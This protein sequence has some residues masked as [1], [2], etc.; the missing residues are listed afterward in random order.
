MRAL[1]E[2]VEEFTGINLTVPHFDQRC[3]YLRGPRAYR[4]IVFPSFQTRARHEYC[5]L[6]RNHL[7]AM[8]RR[9]LPSRARE[10]E[11]WK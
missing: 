7:Y 8:S 4:R 6:S 3:P 11:S 5:G 10:K 9:Y 1:S 2:L